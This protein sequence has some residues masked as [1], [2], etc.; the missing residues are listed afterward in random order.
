MKESPYLTKKDNI[1]QKFRNIPFLHRVG[2]AFVGQI[3]NLSRLRIYQAGETII[4]EGTEDPWFYIL[5][6]GKV[7]VMKGEAE[8]AE[9]QRPGEI[10]GE[11]ALTGTTLRTASVVADAET[12]TLAIN[13]GFAESMSSENQ[14]ACYA[15]IYRF[16]VEVMAERL[17]RTN[18]E[19]RMAQKEL[20]MMKASSWQR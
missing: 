12:V 18:E 14:A 2:D 6:S 15:V 3:I 17:R 5:I 4:T 8:V 13:V 20:E 10:F 16:V 9:I 7:S 1:I 19:L 11:A